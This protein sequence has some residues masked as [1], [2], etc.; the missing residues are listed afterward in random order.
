MDTL[1]GIPR[2]ECPHLSSFNSLMKSNLVLL[3]KLLLH[4]CR[5]DFFQIESACSSSSSC[6]A[7]SLVYSKGLVHYCMIT[8]TG[9]TFASRANLP[10]KKSS[11]EVL[12]HLDFLCHST[13][14]VLGV[15]LLH[16]FGPTRNKFLWTH[17]TRET[18]FNC[19]LVTRHV[20][21]SKNWLCQFKD[22]CIIF[23]QWV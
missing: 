7:A 5:L 4:S 22:S 6:C 17:P 20:P 19:S 1:H 18:N 21:P 14:R 13:M 23:L 10:Q 8:T 11:L 12:F 2:Q 15:M 16:T 3:T 9:M